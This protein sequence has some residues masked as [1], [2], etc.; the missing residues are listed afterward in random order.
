MPLIFHHFS[1]NGAYTES[2]KL[3]SIFAPQINPDH[4]YHCAL[5]IFYFSSHV[6]STI[7]S[8]LFLCSIHSSVFLIQFNSIQQTLIKQLLYVQGTVLDPKPKLTLPSS[9]L[10]SSIGMQLGQKLDKSLQKEEMPN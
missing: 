9:S 6:T 3:I 2:D 8:N 7:T 5:H 4:T 10:H 1:P